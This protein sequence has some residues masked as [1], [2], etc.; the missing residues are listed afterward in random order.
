MAFSAKD[1]LDALGLGIYLLFGVVHLDLWLRRR[2]RRAHLWLAAAATGALFVDGTSLALKFVSDAAPLY[3]LNVIAVAATTSSLLELVAALEGRA[4]GG[5]ARAFQLAL[6][7]AAPFAPQVPPVFVVVLA[8]CGLLLLVAHG[9]AVAAA[10]RGDPDAGGVAR[11]FL[12]LNACLILDIVHELFGWSWIPRGLPIVG[13]SVLFVMAARSLNARA[14]REHSELE[15]LRRDLELR[16]EERT[17][18]LQEA[19]ER[20]AEASRTDPLTGLP[21]RRGFLR[22]AAGALHRRNRSLRPLS[23]VLGD[24]DHFK[25]IND[26]RGHAAGDEVLR[27][28]AETLRVAL[29]GQDVVA[30]WGGEEFILLLPDTGAAG[31]VR[32]AENL[33]AAVAAMRVAPDGEAVEVTIS[34]GCAEHRNE[35]NLESTIAA[36]DAALYRAKGEGRNRVACEPAPDPDTVEIAFA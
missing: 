26:T 30:R 35:R 11:G 24:V 13:F 28:V 8:G 2:E 5:A 12:V 33:R 31:A 3:A 25:R 15:A 9:H 17:L 14:D 7:A 1:L 27:G 10:R 29:R 20:L 22:E 4:T 34:F 19:N 16:V 36:A 6:L 23:V 21:N 18:A 32:A